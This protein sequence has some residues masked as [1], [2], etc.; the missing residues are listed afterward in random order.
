MKRK[1][2]TPWAFKKYKCLQCILQSKRDLKNHLPLQV[3]QISGDT[4][5][6]I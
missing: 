2:Y 5:N 3:P 6:F 1:K 4:V